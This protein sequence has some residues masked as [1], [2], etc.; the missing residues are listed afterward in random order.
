MI[1]CLEVETS[2]NKIE[3]IK[4]VK[5]TKTLTACNVQSKT[6]R[7]QSSEKTSPIA[8]ES[9]VFAIY[10]KRKMI[11]PLRIEL[12]S[13][14]WAEKMIEDS[15]TLANFVWLSR[16][17]GVVV[18]G[19]PMVN[20]L[21]LEPLKN[22]CY[23]DILTDFGRTAMANEQIPMPRTFKL[24]SNE[25]TEFIE[26]YRLTAYSS[27]IRFLYVTGAKTFSESGTINL[28][29]V[30]FAI[31]KLDAAIISV[32]NKRSQTKVSEESNDKIRNIDNN[33]F[34]RFKK[35]YQ[36]VVKFN[37]K[38]IAN[39]A[40]RKEILHRCN[41]IY[42]KCRKTWKDFEK[43]GFYNI[44]LLK[45]ARRS[46]G[47][48]IRLFDEDIDILSYAKENENMKYLVQKYVGE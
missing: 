32:N 39:V 12:L 47:I 13:R 16:S 44:W 15:S 30:N 25:K 26:N 31:E 34:E 20:R 18:E 4:P 7:K 27:F 2:K 33:E 17:N 40:E 3:N 11:E 6:K 45:P 24:F 38:I 5:R 21:K 48:G 19:S 42:K 23:K 43:D 37:S 8:N 1:D 10:E 41:T 22:F 9:K 28:R 14:G 46:L 36:S 35:I 29:W